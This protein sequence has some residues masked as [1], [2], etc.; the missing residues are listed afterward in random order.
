MLQ[1]KDDIEI[2]L[3]V[4]NR[5]SDKDLESFASECLRAPDAKKNEQLKYSETTL[6]LRFNPNRLP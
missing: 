5:L 4:P 3:I 1:T 6:V 2:N